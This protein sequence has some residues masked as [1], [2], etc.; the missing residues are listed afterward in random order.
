MKYLHTITEVDR[1]KSGYFKKTCS[2]CEYTKTYSLKDVLGRVMPQDVGKRV[3][4]SEQ[5]ILQVESKEQLEKRLD[6]LNRI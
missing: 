4:I 3:Y 1:K 5:G 2:C 6:K